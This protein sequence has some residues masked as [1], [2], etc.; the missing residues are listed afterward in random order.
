MKILVTGLSG[1]LGYDAMRELAQRS[2][3]SLGFYYKDN[4]GERQ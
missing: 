1:Q 4:T 2:E 3:D